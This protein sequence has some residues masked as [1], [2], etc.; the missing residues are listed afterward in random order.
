MR[1]EEAIS[2]DCVFV[3]VLFC[4]IL[5]KNPQ[6]MQFVTSFEFFISCCCWCCCFFQL[7]L[8]EFLLMLFVLCG[9]RIR[10][11]NENLVVCV[12]V[13]RENIKGSS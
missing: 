4:Y 3:V 9:N 6:K 7:E 5:M 13:E 2:Q 10:N 12:Y 1:A 8:I 11:R